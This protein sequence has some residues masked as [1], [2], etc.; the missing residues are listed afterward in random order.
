[1]D[2]TLTRESLE[3]DTSS[4]RHVWWLR[5]TATSVSGDPKIFVYHVDSR[6]ATPGLD[7]FECVASAGQMSALP[8][9]EP[10]LEPDE[11]GEVIPYY[12]TASIAMACGSALEADELWDAIQED[13]A[14]LVANMN[15]VDDLSTTATVTFP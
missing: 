8:A 1:M 7:M 11:G 13:A 3:E 2:I 4:A 14:E 10:V 5:I 12:R 9:D 15:A 6:F